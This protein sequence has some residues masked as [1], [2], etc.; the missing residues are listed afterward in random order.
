[1]LTNR[2][3]ARIHGLHLRVRSRPL[4]NICVAL[5]IRRQYATRLALRAQRKGHPQPSRRPTQGFGSVRVGSPRTSKKQHRP[6]LA[7]LQSAAL[8]RIRGRRDR[9][10]EHAETVVLSFELKISH[11][12]TLSICIPA[13]CE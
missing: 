11:A 8:S 10:V 13:A 2:L 1:M 3:L 6:W 7:G 12:Y 9:D 5:L 4:T